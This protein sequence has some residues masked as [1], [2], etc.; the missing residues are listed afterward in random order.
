MLLA[1]VFAVW[2]GW[3]FLHRIGQSEAGDKGNPAAADSAVA[4]INAI[5]NV[6]LISIDTCRADHLSCYGFKRPTTPNIDAAARDGAIFKMALTPTPVTT[7][8]HSSMLTGMY[9][10][11]HGV[12][13]NSYCDLADSN[14]TLAKTLRE[15]G[16]QTAAFVGAFPLDVR[17]G[18]N[19]GFD[20]Y[21]GWFYEEAGKEFWG[22]REGEEVNRPALAWL[23][24]H[25]KQPFFLFLHY[26]D[27]HQPHVQH[28]PYTNPYADD[29]YSGELAYVD[30]CIGRVFDRLRTLG[31]YDNTLLII[32][33]DHGEG[34][35]EHGEPTHAY[36]IYQSTLHV[37]LVIRAPG[38]GKGI[39]VEGNVSLVDIVPTVLDLVGLKSHSPLEGVDLRPALEGGPVPDPQRALYAESLEVTTFECSPLHGVVEGPWKYI[40]APR[41]ELYDLAN[42]PGELTNLA[43]KE[44]RV[45]LRLRGRLEAMCKE[46]EKTAAAPQ[47]GPS[48]V[49]PKAIK[50]LESLGY[51]SGGGMMPASAM[52]TSGEDPKD[53]LPTF[54]FIGNARANMFSNRGRT[55]EGKK[56]LLE[57]AARRP[58][59][60]PLQTWLGEIAL[61]ERRPADA[62]RH[63][64]KVV[65]RL[66][67]LKDSSKKR[68]GGL[69]PQIARAHCDLAS[70]LAME[71]NAAQAAMHYAEAIRGQSDYREALNSLAW[72][73]ATSEDPQLRNGSEAVRLAQRAC[74][75]TGH[76]EVT[77]LDTLAA[78]YAEAGR[79]AEAAQ[80]ARQALDLATQQNQPALAESI[81]AKF[82]RYEA[83][84]PFHESPSSPA[85]TS[86]R[87]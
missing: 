5:R 36:F 70:A 28:R 2:T 51:V 23:D 68:L 34:L 33:A 27:L 73:R 12:R 81:Q 43:G 49:D 54:L 29:H 64:A 84:K 17:F 14:V 31:V 53:F 39:Q 75:F 16:Y 38:C 35:G 7:P 66:D 11:T 18:L 48:A 63:F 52:D 71:G 61:K 10:P 57:I 20:T 45:D 42:D 58:G 80:T 56:A 44:P 50:Q 72:I 21:N 6:V 74:Q 62:A 60:I 9:P 37:P 24:D 19:Q 8:A 67:E 59:L 1:A 46:W 47:R 87:P 69:T 13:F 25:A 4:G 78:A 3:H 30:A 77:A 83:K 85:K 26:Y 15:A 76:R 65:A 40:L 79:F 55:D 41:P 32:T 82:R 86:I 22:R